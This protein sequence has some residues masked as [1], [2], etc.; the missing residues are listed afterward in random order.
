V[1]LEVLEEYGVELEEGASGRV[2]IAGG[3]HT[4]TVLD[5][6][7][8][9]GWAVIE[10]R[11]DAQSATLKIG[12]SA[13]FDTDGNGLDDLKVTLEGI[14]DGKTDLK[15]EAL[16]EVAPEAPAAPPA[17]VEEAPKEPEEAPAGPVEEEAPLE[18]PAGRGLQIALLAIIVVIVLAAVWYTQGKK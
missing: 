5:V 18:K 11:S 6:N 17:E 15:F 10:I 16:E 2:Y 13:T 14:T 8:A 4:V 3:W 7:E 9:E 1:D 12:E